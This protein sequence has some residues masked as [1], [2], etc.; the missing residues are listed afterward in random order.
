MGSLQATLDADGYALTA[1]L[2]DAFELQSLKV[3][4][5]ASRFAG[6]GTRSLLVFDWC[7][8]LVARLRKS[9]IREAIGDSNPA[10]Q[11]TLFDKTPRHNWL[12]A[13]HQDLSIPVASRVQHSELRNWTEKEGQHFVQPPDAL[14][15]S[16][17][18]VRLHIDDCGVDNGPLRVVPGSHKRGRIP[19][20]DRL[21]IRDAVGEVACPALAGEAWVFKPL[22]LHASSKAAVPARRRIL[23]FLFGPPWPGYGLRWAY[24]I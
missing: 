21:A 13:P 20:S 10:V 12:V 8:T 16:L 4:L 3:A 7:R 6:A 11:C 18:A 19:A 5:D 23:H 1:P 24:A 14:L 2:I 22:L 15:R 17:V 9:A